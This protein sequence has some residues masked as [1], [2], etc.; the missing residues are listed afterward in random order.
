V[1]ESGDEFSDKLGDVLLNFKKDS[2]GEIVI[3]RVDTGEQITP[4]RLF[5]FAWAAFHPNT[6]LYKAN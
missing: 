5:W 2:D 1:F 6:K 3:T 4:I